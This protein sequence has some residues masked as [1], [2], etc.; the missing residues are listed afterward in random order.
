VQGREHSG[1]YPIIKIGK[2]M[3]P[4]K[5]DEVDAPT[6]EIVSWLDKPRLALPDGTIATVAEQQV[7]KEKPSRS[8]KSFGDADMDDEIPF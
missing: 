7:E 3:K 4:G 8:V 6:L 2:T 1:C 5:A